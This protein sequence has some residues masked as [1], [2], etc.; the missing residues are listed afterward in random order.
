[1]NFNTLIRW[2]SLSRG[3]QSNK[4]LLTS[5]SAR[6]I[7]L[8]G[9]FGTVLILAYILNAS[10]LGYYYIYSAIGISISFIA[11][12][13]FFYGF[14]RLYPDEEN[15]F[16]DYTRTLFL[17][18][19]IFSI[20]CIILSNIILSEWEG[21][22]FGIALSIVGFAFGECLFSQVT[23][24][25]SL[26]PEKSRYLHAV[27]IR[28]IAIFATII[29]LHKSDLVAGAVQIINIFTAS[30]ILACVASSGLWRRQ[31]LR[32]T[33]RWSIIRQN[34]SF[35]WPYMATQI[36]RQP[37]ER[38]DRLFVGLFIG[39]VAAGQLGVATDLAR[40]VIQGLCVNAR[41]AYGRQ[42]IA[43]YDAGDHAGA[44]GRLRQAQD[45]I[46]LM[47]APVAFG[48]SVFGA[49]M[50]APLFSGK[51]T[52]DGLTVLRI[53]AFA[54]CF[55]A[56]RLYAT[57]IVFEFTRKTRLLIQ[58]AA[59]GIT[60]QIAL[61]A[62]LGLGFGIMGVSAAIFGVNAILYAVTD[63]R[64]R[65][66]FPEAPGAFTPLMALLFTAVAA[67]ACYFLIG[68]WL[69]LSIGGVAGAALV[70]ALF[71][72]LLFLLIRMMRKSARSESATVH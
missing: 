40:R 72:T 10:Q 14:Q 13:P 18:P 44:G 71:E 22:F 46:L 29:A 41:L 31:F 65:R 62:I 19:L 17:P 11:L 6:I 21:D 34:F 55:E 25:N 67:A 12:S 70:V 3:I 68:R 56:L 5:V 45:V 27:S 58:V 33:F 26:N 52:G 28:T 16:Q 50:A 4:G 35:G 15:Q 49:N 57:D 1:M 48:L 60:A 69:P 36:M 7:Q 64:A 9:G 47:A 20:L 42:I 32:G 53:A 24:F 63:H 61:F 37:L 66:V 51:L 54:F 38:G 43:R 23:N 8:A 30:A 39:P 2:Q 59:I